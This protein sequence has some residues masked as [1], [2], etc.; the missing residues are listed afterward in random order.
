M[1][2]QTISAVRYGYGLSPRFAPP[3][4]AAAL[5]A[6]LDEPDEAAARFAVAGMDEAQ[7]LGQTL[8]EAR[9]ANR[10]KAP[11]AEAQLKRA[12]QAIRANH[13]D[14]LR[15]QM[16]RAVQ[17][18]VGFRE[19]L[20][21][22]WADHFTVS[23]GNVVHRPKAPAF[24]EEVV[25]PHLMGSFSQMLRAAAT[26]P[27]ML[28][29]LDQ[30]RSF[31]PASKAGLKRDRGLNENL[32]R[33]ILELHTLGVGAGYD[34][35]DVRQFAELLTGLGVTRDGAFKFFPARAEPGVEMVLG[36]RYGSEGR[37]R[38]DDILAALDDLAA[39]PETARHIAR[40]LVVH[41]V[42]DS[43]DPA[44]VEHVAAAYAAS[45]GDLPTVYAALIEHPGGWAPLGGKVRQPWDFVAASLRAL[46]LPEDRLEG[47]KTGQIGKRL[48]Q[49]MAAMGQPYLRASGPDGWPE[50]AEAW[51][52]PQLLAE[53]ISWAAHLVEVLGVLPEPRGF[54][55]TALA[56]R[57]SP[58][59]VQA[60]QRSENPR[61]AVGLVLAS[62]E[63]NRR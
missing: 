41:F 45:G 53:R 26:H 57:A 7:P 5:L 36:Q 3:I 8:V 34:Q 13:M 10:Q 16:Q 11:G 19:R 20:A 42:S 1:Y 15:A 63:F 38:L 60:V 50:E 39:R 27:A 32:A 28:I 40:K 29:Y 44:L 52:T 6:S 4:D 14:A 35:D 49:P 24:S 59:L 33:E 58:A 25:R 31:G 17:S 12:K 54:L 55:Q 23:F 2:N 37:A 48:R 47:F 30:N 43:P 51:I 61:E 21:W 56:E 9:R 62:A 22:F 18:P 46:D